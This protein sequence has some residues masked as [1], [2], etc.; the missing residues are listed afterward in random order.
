VGVGGYVVGWRG[1]K[2][3]FRGQTKQQDSVAL[4]TL[5]FDEEGTTEPVCGE[6]LS[7]TAHCSTGPL[8]ASA[9]MLGSRFGARIR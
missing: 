4:A 2:L 1:K 5:A 7:G 3:S 6:L 8:C 9:A